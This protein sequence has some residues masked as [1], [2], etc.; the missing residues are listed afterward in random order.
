MAA[1]TFKVKLVKSP[2]GAQFNQVATVQGMG[3]KRMGN[4]RTLVDTPSARGMVNTV[5]HLVVVVA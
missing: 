5:R 2:I 3:L 1:K 4:I